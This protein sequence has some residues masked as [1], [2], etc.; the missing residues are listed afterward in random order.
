[1]KTSIQSNLKM[2][3]TMLELVFVI[4]IVGILSVMI[5][6]SFNNNNARKA[7]DQIISHIRY[8]QHLAMMDNKF[9]PAVGTWFQQRWYIEFVPDP[10]NAGND[11]YSIRSNGNYANNIIDPTKRLTGDSTVNLRTPELDLTAEYGTNLRVTTCGRTLSF[12]NMGRPY[13][14][15]PNAAATAYVNILQ[16]P[17][18]LTFN[19]GVNDATIEIQPETGY[20]RIQ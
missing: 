9:D 2:A 11:I 14:I 17:C 16:V 5:A 10:I 13:L 8:T 18:T 20:V 19:D 1:M 15:N 3:F 4:V 6:P 12:D 7:A